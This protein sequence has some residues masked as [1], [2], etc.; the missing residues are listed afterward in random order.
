MMISGECSGAVR[1]EEPQVHAH[2][3]R[4]IDGVHIAVVIGRRAVLFVTATIRVVEVEQV[5]SVGDCAFLLRRLRRDRLRNER[6][7]WQRNV[8]LIAVELDLAA[9]VSRSTH[10]ASPR[11]ESVVDRIHRHVC[12]AIAESNIYNDEVVD[13]IHV[14]AYLCFRE[15]F[16]H[17]RVNDDVTRCA[18]GDFVGDVTIEVVLSIGPLDFDLFK[19]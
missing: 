1:V 9:F 5:E 13:M 14:G 18:V 11:E 7:R 12:V 4:Y 2:V 16:L 19:D 15:T 3:S 8:A 17:R 6:A 10:H